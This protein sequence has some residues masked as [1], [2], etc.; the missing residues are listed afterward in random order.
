MGYA[1]A[2]SWAL[3]AVILVVVVVVF[4]VT[5]ARVYFA[6]GARGGGL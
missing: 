4:R 2:L 3:F 6:G 1:A 5:S